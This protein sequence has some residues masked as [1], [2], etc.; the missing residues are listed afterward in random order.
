MTGKG[1]QQDPSPEIEVEQTGTYYNFKD[2]TPKRVKYILQRA[3]SRGDI[4]MLYKLYD[5]MEV[6][7]TRYS[8]IIG[9]LRKTTSGMPLRIIPEEGRTEKEREVAEEYANYARSVLK[10]LD[11]QALTRSFVE[12]YIRGASV[13]RLNWEMEDLPYNRRMWFPSD[14]DEIDGR[15]FK[16]EIDPSDDY[17]GELKIYTEGDMD[18]TAISE[19]PFDN[20]IFLEYGDQ[21]RNYSRAGV[22][23]KVLPWWIALRFVQ[24][25][26]VQYIESYGTPI[27]VGKYPAGASKKRR[28][29]MQKF[30]EKVGRNGYGLFPHGME[31]DL[32]KA[33]ETG[34]ITTYQD[35]MDKAHLEYSIHILGQAGTTG[36]GREGSFAQTS[37][38]NGIRLDI[39]EDVSQLAAKGYQKLIEKGIRLNYGDDNFREHLVPR[40]K[41]IIL[42]SKDAK[43][44]AAA[45]AQMSKL[46]ADIP[47]NYIYEKILG[48]RKPQDGEMV[49]RAGETFE[50]G[51]DEA[52]EPI[53]P[54]ANTMGG[55]GGQTSEN[56]DRSV[57][58]DTSTEE[59]ESGDNA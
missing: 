50:K 26:W 48:V 53:R 35:F 29:Q 21:R 27:R 34:N 17:Y 42:N 22:A 16:Q 1:P 7:D 30:L 3:D 56:G 5:D 45:V 36:E 54:E 37:I 47:V 38:L 41:P 55:A 57:V 4:S 25:W 23:R 31:V 28:M 6:T 13:F 59:Q 32:L 19:L 44:R 40:I 12:P 24:T 14:V 33:D 15:H 2:I 10:T 51:S 9:Q 52:P 39:I 11:T 46:G 58:N 18:A 49:I 20:H 8:G 43:K